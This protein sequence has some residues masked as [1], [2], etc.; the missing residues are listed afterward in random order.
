MRVPCKFVPPQHCKAPGRTASFSRATNVPA[1]SH[2]H[3]DV[4]LI[5]KHSTEYIKMNTTKSTPSTDTQT[6]RRTCKKQQISITIQ[7]ELLLRLDKLA[8]ELGQSRASMINIAIYS[9]IENGLKIN[10]PS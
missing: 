6:Q 9:I 7:P 5:V 3:S 10:T 2:A 4:G 8:K 1:K